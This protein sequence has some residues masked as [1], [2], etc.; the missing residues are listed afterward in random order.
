MNSDQGGTFSAAR[1]LLTQRTLSLRASRNPRLDTAVQAGHEP[2]LWVRRGRGCRDLRL[3]ADED[4]TLACAKR[5]NGCRPI[6][7]ELTKIRVV[8]P[9]QIAEQTAVVL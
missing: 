6:I 1:S 5:G 7:H 8:C 9:V 4:A 2:L 3:R